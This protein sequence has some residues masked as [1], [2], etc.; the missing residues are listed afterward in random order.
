MDGDDSYGAAVENIANKEWERNAQKGGSRGGSP[1][2]RR[3]KFRLLS[4]PPGKAGEV[5]VAK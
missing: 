5:P 2:G 1:R 3:G 4:G